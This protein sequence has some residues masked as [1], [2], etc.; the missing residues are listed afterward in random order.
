MRRAPWPAPGKALGE[1]AVNIEALQGTTWRG[2]AFVRFVP[3]SPDRASR[4]LDA[5]GFEHTTR[6]VLIV[7]VLDEPGALGQ[8]ALVMATAGV[9][10]DAVYVTTMGHVVRPDCRDHDAPQCRP[11]RAARQRCRPVDPAGQE[12]ILCSVVKHRMMHR[13][14]TAVWHRR[15][16]RLLWHCNHPTDRHCLLAECMH[17]SVSAGP[18]D[19]ARERRGRCGLWLR[20]A[21]T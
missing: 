11:M 19:A 12:L 1:G 4:A 20:G 8:V 6:E 14:P 15:T 7:R 13:R 21:G 18:D 5:A 9:N 16:S 3:D 10:I 17:V 2:E